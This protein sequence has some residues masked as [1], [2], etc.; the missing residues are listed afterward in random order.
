M[1]GRQEHRPARMRA[2]HA[3]GIA[4]AVA[5]ASQPA[6]AEEDVEP[7][8][9]RRL[10]GH[11]F[12]PSTLVDWGFIDSW[13]TSTTLGGLSE[14]DFTPRDRIARIIGTR[15]TKV[16]LISQSFAGSAALTRWLG[17]TLRVSA[18]GIV[19]YDAVAGVAVG[20]HGAYRAEAAILLRLL[21]LEHVQLTARG[22]LGWGETRSII[23]ARLPERPFVTGDEGTI[24]PSLIADIALASWLGVQASGSYEWRQVEILQ[25]DDIQTVQGAVALTVSLPRIPVTLLGGFEITHDFNRDLASAISVAVF[26]SS[27]TRQRAE[28]GF[29]YQGRGELDLGAGVAYEGDSDGDEKRGYAFVHMGYYF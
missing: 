18:L 21:R 3:V 20:A 24:R 6:L 25:E 17:A 23:P 8:V 5:L 12:V 1:S 7:D 11:R 28:L 19:P 27:A 13:F 26:G 29:Y 15:E 14:F 10:G 2:W 16:I 4:A 9:A 22:A